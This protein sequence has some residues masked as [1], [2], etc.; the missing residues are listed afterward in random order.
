MN[1]SSIVIQTNPEFLEELVNKIKESDLCE[2]HIHD[3]KGRIIVT[4]EGANVDEEIAKMKQIQAIPKVI[5]A[6]L[7]Y[8]YNEE[9]LD[10]EREKL[11]KV[12]S[13]PEWLNDEKAKAEDI[14]YHGDLRKRL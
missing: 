3:E 11:E 8:S 6:S 2:Y 5:S 12:D 10:I 4:I 7:V 14:V 9:D 13:I 1:I